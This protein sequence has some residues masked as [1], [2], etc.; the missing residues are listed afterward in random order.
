MRVFDKKLDFMPDFCFLGF[1][2][3]SRIGGKKSL[4]F[5]IPHFSKLRDVLF[6]WGFLMPRGCSTKDLEHVT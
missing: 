1:N 3:A 4:V 6:D 2:V 5:P